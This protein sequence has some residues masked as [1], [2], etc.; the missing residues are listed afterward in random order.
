MADPFDDG[1]SVMQRGD[2]KGAVSLFNQAVV[3]NEKDWRPFLK[4]G[5]CLY[6]MGD[7]RLASNDFGEVVRL[8]KT[9]ADGFFWQANA[10]A[11]LGIY[12]LALSDYT[13][14]QKLSPNYIADH[15]LPII[16]Q[17][18]ATAGDTTSGAGEPASTVTVTATA[19]NSTPSVFHLKSSLFGGLKDPDHEIDQL[20]ATISL[21]PLNS[22]LLYQRAKAYIQ[23]NRYAVALQDLNNAIMAEPNNASYYLARGF[24]YHKEGR[25]VVGMEDI[26]QA[27]LADPGLPKSIDFAS[28]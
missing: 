26:K 16:S 12:N 24:V 27:Q 7:F 8:N 25:D 15:T 6:L 1:Q 2:L 22:K 23:S 13:E 18:V 21:D 5:Q 14:V 19:S 10:Y 9:S 20:S 3:N 17:A 11:K 28:E 4:R